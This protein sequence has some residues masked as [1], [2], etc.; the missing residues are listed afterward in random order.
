M[1]FFQTQ[2][3]KV[4][5]ICGVESPNQTFRFQH[6]TQRP[7]RISCTFRVSQANCKFDNPVDISMSLH[8]ESEVFSLSNR[9]FVRSRQPDYVLP[10]TLV[11]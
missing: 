4:L 1:Y 8:F 9:K 10:A 3:H 6:V 5:S 2:D 11:S 7:E